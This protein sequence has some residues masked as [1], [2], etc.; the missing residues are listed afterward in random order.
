MI[1]I[2]INIF[3]I[4]RSKFSFKL[5][6]FSFLSTWKNFAQPLLIENSIGFPITLTSQACLYCI[7]FFSQLFF[8]SFFVFFFSSRAC[9][10]ASFFSSRN[11]FLFSFDMSTVSFNPASSDFMVMLT[12]DLCISLSA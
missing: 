4:R 10:F 3:F 12:N 2:I 5:C 8:F 6:R 7:G 11:A 1:R 9:F